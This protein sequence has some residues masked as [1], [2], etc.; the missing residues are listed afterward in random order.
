MFNI[1]INN[2]ENEILKM[3]IRNIFRIWFLYVEIVDDKTTRYLTIDIIYIYI[4]VY[5]L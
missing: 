1:F 3:N 2:N 4:Y 5:L